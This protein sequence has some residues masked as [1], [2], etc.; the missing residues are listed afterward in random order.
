[1][2]LTTTDDAFVR[3][4]VR[5]VATLAS[6]I[7]V[8]QDDGRPGETEP[9]WG[10]LRRHVGATGDHIR[11][12]R[13]QFRDNI[14]HLPD[15]AEAYYMARGGW[16][17]WL[18]GVTHGFYVAGVQV[19]PGL[20]RVGRWSVPSLVLEAEELRHICVESAHLIGKTFPC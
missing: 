7:E 11:R 17:V 18:Q 2:G 5:W 16:A 1:M 8:F 10:R 15:D 13:L 19:E 6:G 4:R 3:D 12:L 20:V 14:V 9:A